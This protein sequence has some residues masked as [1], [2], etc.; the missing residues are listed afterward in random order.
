[1]EFDDIFRDGLYHPGSPVISA[2][3]AAAEQAG[4]SGQTLLRGVISGYEVSNRIAAAMVP[5][6]YDWWHTTAT[7]GFFGATAAAS[8]ILN[9]TA[10]QAAHAIGTAGTMA[11]LQQAF[12]ADAE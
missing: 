10:A 3:L 4:A 2:A 12:R 1:M 8:T 7:V 6:H 5:A 9:L 11:G